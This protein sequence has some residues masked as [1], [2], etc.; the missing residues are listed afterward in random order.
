MY[1]EAIV[2]LLYAGFLNTPAFAQ[3]QRH[4]YSYKNMGAYVKF[5]LKHEILYIF[6]D[7][8]LLH[9]YIVF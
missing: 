7:L 2:Y 6:I 3:N 1:R 4:M 9:L 8:Y 5:T